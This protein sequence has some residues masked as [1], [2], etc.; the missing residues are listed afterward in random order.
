MKN[1]IL[2]S[3]I[4]LTL[5]IAACNSNQSKSPIEA[6]KSV[7]Y[8]VGYIS[9]HISTDLY[10]KTELY[11]L[12]DNFLENFLQIYSQYKGIQ[13]V[14]AT[15]LPKE[16]GVVLVERLQEGREL[17]QVQ[18][19]NR[20]WVFLI[21]T[22]GYGTQRI[23]D[24]LP[25]A[26]NLTNQTQDILETEIWTTEREVDE[27][28]SITRKYEWKRSIEHVTQK[29]YEDNPAKYFNSQTI[30]NKYFINDNYCFE[31][32]ISEDIP[33]YS[34]VIF[35]YR[36]E[37][38]E[39]YEEIVQMLCAFCEDHDILFA[40]VHNNFNQFELFD[41]KLNLVATLDVTSFM[42]LQ[43]GFIFLKKD[44]VPKT[45][46]FGSFERLKIEVKR[47]FRIVETKKLEERIL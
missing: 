17:Y 46:P 5:W 19:Q 44:D 47:Y 8:P 31:K 26:I 33:N 14:M 45:V 15:A 9:H 6:Q 32:I 11:P 42:D 22:S 13:P 39:E 12:E 16:W 10:D 23:L 30:N 27:T 37:K 24:I 20:E 4:I 43:E 21:I 40:E 36:G 3:F 34:A 18:S 25:V 2:I 7:E 28:F 35:Y 41:Y 1:S 38:P 29:E